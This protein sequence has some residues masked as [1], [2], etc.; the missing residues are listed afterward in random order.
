[1]T[2]IPPRRFL[3]SFKT[4]AASRGFETASVFEKRFHF[5]GRFAKGCETPNDFMR[6]AR[7]TVFGFPLA[8]FLTGTGSAASCILSTGPCF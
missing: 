5:C 8:G 2:K 4:V 7:T 6:F 1:M 3:Q